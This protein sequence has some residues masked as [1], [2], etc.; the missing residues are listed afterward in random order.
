MGRLVSKYAGLRPDKTRASEAN[1]DEAIKR[2]SPR[3][4][5]LVR[6]AR[7]IR[8]VSTAQ[9]RVNNQLQILFPAPEHRLI[10]D[11]IASE[12]LSRRSVSDRAATRATA[13]D[14]WSWDI[15]QALCKQP[16]ERSAREAA[17]SAKGVRSRGLQIDVTRRVRNAEQSHSPIVVFYRCRKLF[18]PKNLCCK[19]SGGRR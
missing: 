6:I 13:R 17:K 4:A 1:V 9:S 12:R 2:R 16:N 5:S 11:D 14:G 19:K 3:I 7:T 8:L 10:N 18:G 15:I